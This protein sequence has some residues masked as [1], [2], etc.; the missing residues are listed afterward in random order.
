MYIPNIAPP[1]T[2]ANTIAL[3]EVEFIRSR[4]YRRSVYSLK[5]TGGPLTRFPFRSTLTSIQSVIVVAVVKGRNCQK[6]LA[7]SA[8]LTEITW[9]QIAATIGNKD[10]AIYSDLAQ[11]SPKRISPRMWGRVHWLPRKQSRLNT[12]TKVGQRVF[13]NQGLRYCTCLALPLEHDAPFQGESPFPSQLGPL[14]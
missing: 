13:C 4:I 3:I 5:T 9:G 11:C 6:Y 7:G 8:G 2:Q 10:L 12:S 1:K 14:R